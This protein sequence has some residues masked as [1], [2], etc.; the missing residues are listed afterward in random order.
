L[1]HLHEVMLDGIVSHV[2]IR[3]KLVAGE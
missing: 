1:T 3:F 2:K